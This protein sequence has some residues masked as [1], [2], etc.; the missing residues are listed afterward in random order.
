[1]LLYTQWINVIELVEWWWIA[2]KMTR[3]F[4]RKPKCCRE[5]DLTSI[6]NSSGGVY[7]HVH[8]GRVVVVF[9]VIA[10]SASYIRNAFLHMNFVVELTRNR[11]GLRRTNTVRSVCANW[12][13]IFLNNININKSYRIQNSVVVDSPNFTCKLERFGS[14]SIGDDLTSAVC[15]KTIYMYR[16][17]VVKDVMTILHDKCI[18]T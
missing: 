11:F 13:V 2:R 1:M 5:Y 6:S 15:T 16:A 17:S 14:T 8:C 9:P 18:L 3:S 7:L 4:V 10:T 12:F